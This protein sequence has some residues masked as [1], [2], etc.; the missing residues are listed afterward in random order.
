[1]KAMPSLLSPTETT[2]SLQ[3]IA[4]CLITC[5]PL[6]SDYEKELTT[7]FVIMLAANMVKS[8][9]GPITISPSLTTLDA[10]TQLHVQNELYAVMNALK[11]KIPGDMDKSYSVLSRN[12][13]PNT[14]QDTQQKTTQQ[15]RT[16]QTGI[17]LSIVCPTDPE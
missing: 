11:S 12:N 2:I 9:D 3:A 15:P 4:Y 13:P 17:P 6:L 16:T 10:I 8:Q 1:M 7:D 14:S 5:R